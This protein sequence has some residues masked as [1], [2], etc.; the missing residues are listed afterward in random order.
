M[1]S[2]SRRKKNHHSDSPIR[3]SRERRRQRNVADPTAIKHLKHPGPREKSRST[4]NEECITSRP[5]NSRWGRALISLCAIKG[6]NIIVTNAWIIGS[7]VRVVSR[8]PSGRLVSDLSPL[9]SSSAGPRREI[10]LTNA[11]P[12]RL[13]LPA[14][15]PLYVFHSRFTPCGDIAFANY[16]V[17]STSIKYLGRSLHHPVFFQ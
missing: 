8:R 3:F 2:Q 1:F 6:R 15:K 12:A 5:N 14:Y 4:N 17:P 7:A 16:N 11:R 13:V 9:H 10:S